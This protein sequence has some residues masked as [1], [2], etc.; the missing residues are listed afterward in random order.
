MSITILYFL[1]FLLRALESTPT[2]YNAI[3]HGIINVK[4]EDTRRMK[5][6]VKYNYRDK[7]QTSIT[8][9]PYSIENRP[10]EVNNRLVFGYFEL[11]TVLGTKR[12]KH[13]CL[14]TLTERKTRFEIIFKLQYKNSEEVVNKINQ[15]KTFMNKHYDKIFKSFTTDN[16]SE[17][18]DFL[19]IIQDS[20][21][22]IYFC[23]PYCSGEKVQMKKVIV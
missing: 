4:I 1:S 15:I 5:Y 2:I 17:F 22:K 14:L 9:L 18:A 8:K 7:T 16:G 11:D 21:T 19:G 12:G 10:N 20:K 3:R 6:D 23:H 13:E